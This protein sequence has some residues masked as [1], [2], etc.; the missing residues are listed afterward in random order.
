MLQPRAT[1]LIELAPNCHY[2]WRFQSHLGKRGRTGGND[3]SIATWLVPVKG[4]S[5]DGAMHDL[6]HRKQHLGEKTY[7]TVLI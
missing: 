3:A 4:A 2:C 7:K 1:R 6:V 5:G